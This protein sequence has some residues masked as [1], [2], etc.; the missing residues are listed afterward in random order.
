MCPMEKILMDVLSAI[1]REKM[2]MTQINFFN[3]L[4]I[5]WEVD[6]L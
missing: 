2:K 5:F 3:R 4:S 6:C 1:Y